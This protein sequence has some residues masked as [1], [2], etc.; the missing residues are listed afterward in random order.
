MTPPVRSALAL[1]I[2]CHGLAAGS[3]EPVIPVGA[4]CI[5]RSLRPTVG[6]ENHEQG[7][8]EL[9]LGLA[10]G[11]PTLCAHFK[12]LQDWEESTAPPQPVGTAAC[13]QVDATKQRLAPIAPRLLPGLPVHTELVNGC[14]QG[15]CLP[16]ATPL[17]TD[18]RP[19][20]ALNDTSGLAAILIL[21]SMS[22]SMNGYV[23][24]PSTKK[25][26]R[27]FVVN[28]EDVITRVVFLG[29]RIV[30]QHCKAAA[31]CNFRVFA[32]IAPT[33]EPISLTVKGK[34]F[35]NGHLGML[36]VLEPGSL[37]FADVGWFAFGRFDAKTNT[38]TTVRNKKP[39][40]CARQAIDDMQVGACARK[41]VDPFA[42]AY[43]IA[44][45]KTFLARL[46][47]PRSGDLV[48]LGPSLDERSRFNAY[49]AK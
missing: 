3:P 5:P 32:T 48:T 24:D 34:S 13:W 2:A 18:A 8:L 25:L 41:Q 12:R 1:V 38:V 42:D 14:A 36:T 39:S 15:F 31:H 4:T 7:Q 46:S 9:Q 40:K 22:Q 6:L 27:T 19:M 16:K 23:F 44:T 26:L 17:P 35:T 11:T 21:H 43:V 47:A 28:A 37:G 20:I 49:C 29:D 30:A 45:G 10:D 33:P